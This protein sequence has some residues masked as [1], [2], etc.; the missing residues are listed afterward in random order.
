[1]TSQVFRG[2]N[3]TQQ[4]IS[5]SDQKILGTANP[6]WL[7]VEGS[8]NV[9][10]TRNG[11]DVVLLGRQI[12]GIFTLDTSVFNGEVLQTSPLAC[13]QDEV[14]A[15]VRTGAGDDYVSLGAGD[16]KIYLGSGNNFLD[17][18][19]G[20][21]L[22]DSDDNIIGLKATPKL[23]SSAGSGDD[24]FYLSGFANRTI[25]AGKGNNLI[26]LGSGDANIN[27]S[28][29]NDVISSELSITTY[30]F[31]G[32]DL[33]L[34]NQTINAGDGDNQIAVAPYGETTIKTGKGEDF[35]LAYGI[36]GSSSVNISAGNGNNTIVTTDTNSIIKSGSGDDLI[37]AG[38]G[39]D[40]IFVGNGNN[41]INLRG[42]TVSLPNPLATDT[43][44]FGS[45][46]EIIGGGNDKVYLGQGTDTVI[47]GSSGFA[48]IYNFDC[49]DRLNVSG[50][51]ASF[52]RIGNDTLISSGCNSLGILKGY[53][54][55][56]GL[57]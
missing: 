33:P 29:G 51:N 22:F 47:L 49:S 30:I 11:N 4:I 43:N 57:V 46:V 1:M 9:V 3:Y 25:N 27:T 8:N 18:Y 28:S 36:P 48:T 54:G 6:D 10:N 13:N 32:A 19:G 52:S 21:Y 14:D 38:S 5:E 45:S 24:I 50:L 39:D 7:I 53:T 26:L 17:D 35:I 16:H 12:D 23:V 15:T 34:Y 56:V 31:S 42:E 41:L 55:S 44:L 40:T 37:F 2:I 20:N